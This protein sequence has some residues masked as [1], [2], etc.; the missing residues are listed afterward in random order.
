MLKIISTTIIT[1]FL[2]LNAAG[3]ETNVVAAQA[4]QKSNSGG[5]G[6]FTGPDVPSLSI[7]RG[8]YFNKGVRTSDGRTDIPKLIAALKKINAT[9]YMHLVWDEKHYPQAWND[10]I[11][12]APEFQKANIKL[13]LYLTPPSEGVP[14]PFHGNYEQW[15]VECAKLAAK[16]PVIQGI[17]IDDFNGNVAFFTPTY[18]KKIMA[19]AHKIYPRLSL[20]VIS[21]FGYEK[22]ISKH[23]E[24]GAIDGVILPYIFPHKNH[25]ETKTLFSQISSYRKFLDEMTQKSG[26][27]NQM[28]LIVMIY[29]S[30]F[31]ASPDNP[32]PS[33]VKECIDIALSA[34]RKGLA[35]GVVTYG[36]PKDRIEYLNV[37]SSLYK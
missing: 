12:M 37:G 5:F 31:S 33:Y 23:I 7:I 27:R 11:K 21:Y 10:F 25:S 32:T 24:Q 9:D 15:A 13:W 17:C 26:Y 19:S 14:D 22:T 2:V 4:S 28:P 35:N 18:C 16:Y 8:D 36:L 29:A 6:G 34:T 3:I 1:L 30:K 20:L